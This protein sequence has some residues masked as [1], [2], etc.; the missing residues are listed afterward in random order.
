MRRTHTV[1]RGSLSSII[2][3]LSG[4]NYATLYPDRYAYSRTTWS[5]R[6]DPR[7]RKKEENLFR[8][9]I[10]NRHV[11]A[12]S[13]SPPPHMSNDDDD[14]SS[15]RRS[16]RSLRRAGFRARKLFLFIAPFSA[17][18]LRLNHCASLYWMGRT[19]C[20]VYS[21]RRH[22]VS[23]GRSSY[24]FRPSS[25]TAVNKVSNIPFD[26]TPIAPEEEEPL[27]EKSGKTLPPSDVLCVTTLRALT[28]CSLWTKA[29]KESRETRTEIAII[30]RPNLS[31]F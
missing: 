20:M 30:W 23:A 18:R 14:D 1:D 26:R 5:N 19:R 28:S 31:R 24:A 8:R 3:V 22:S 6:E 7:E 15:L 10:E 25:L 21:R 27:G 29:R 11:S 9:N 16:T 13:P 12:F 4:R 2:R 17:G